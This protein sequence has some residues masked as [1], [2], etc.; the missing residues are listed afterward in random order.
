MADERPLVPADPGDVQQA[1][2][3]A[4]THYSGHPRRR[5]RFTEAEGLKVAI[6]AGHLAKELAQAGFIIMRKPPME[7]GW[8]HLMGPDK[9]PVGGTKT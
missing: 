8:S 6:T 4:L 3:A 1:L 5:A 7:H 2:E 9:P